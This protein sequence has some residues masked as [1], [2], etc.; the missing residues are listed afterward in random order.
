MCVRTAEIF[1]VKY[2]L[3]GTS[4][5][6]KQELPAQVAAALLDICPDLK[7]A[8]PLFWSW[9]FAKLICIRPVFSTTLKKI[10]TSPLY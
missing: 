4:P 9:K 5:V 2:V 3:P 6:R 1:I 7:R 8:A 10:G